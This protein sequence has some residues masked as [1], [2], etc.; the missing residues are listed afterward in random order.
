MNEKMIS[1]RDDGSITVEVSQ[2]SIPNL[3]PPQE[4]DPNPRSFDVKIYSGLIG[5]DS[6][7]LFK[8]LN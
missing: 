7:Q 6:D 4:S 1:A 2:Q 5:I 8:P 3:E